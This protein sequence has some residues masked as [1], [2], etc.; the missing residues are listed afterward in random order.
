MQVSAINFSKLYQNN[1]KNSSFSSFSFPEIKDTVSFGSKN[2]VEQ[3]VGKVFDPNKT[4]INLDGIK[5]VV[6]RD[7]G[8]RVAYT[9]EEAQRINLF[10]GKNPNQI[11]SF[12]TEHNNINMGN[13][14]LKKYQAG[15]LGCV[16][17]ELPLAMKEA[18]IDVRTVLPYHGEL[19]DEADYGKMLIVRLP[20]DKRPKDGEEY[21]G[22]INPDWVHKV[23]SDYVPT[24]NEFFVVLNDTQ[25]ENKKKEKIGYQYVK[26]ED[27]GIKGEIEALKDGFFETEKI[28]YRIFRQKQTDKN[29]ETIYYVHIPQVAAMKKCY[30]K[31]GAYKVGFKIGEFWD[32]YVANCTRAFVNAMPDF[33]EKENFNPANV[34]LHDRQT[35]PVLF[36]IIRRS[37]EGQKFFNGIKCHSILHNPGFD[38]QG[39]FE[40]MHDFMKIMYDEKDFKTLQ[41]R[42]D[43][44]ELKELLRKPYEEMTKDEKQFI[45]EFFTPYFSELL[46][47][48]GRVNST[49]M[50]IAS[51]KINPE[52]STL[53]TVSR[54]YGE[55]MVKYTGIA[56][57]L[58]E[59]F[60]EVTDRIIN[61]T[62]GSL[63][64]SLGLNKRGNFAAGDNGLTTMQLEYSPYN[65]MLNSKNE[66]I[67]FSKSIY[68]LIKNPEK[69]EDKESLSKYSKDVMKNIYKLFNYG[70]KA[71]DKNTQQ[72]F[73]EY[74]KPIITAMTGN[75]NNNPFINTDKY[76]KEETEIN[77]KLS[78][79]EKSLKDKKISQDDYNNEKA[80][81]NK[82]KT[83]L[84]TLSFFNAVRSDIQNTDSSIL[85]KYREGLFDSVKKLMDKQASLMEKGEDLTKEEKAILSFL[86]TSLDNYDVYTISVKDACDANKKWFLQKI[87]DCYSDDKDET[88][89]KLNAL[90]LNSDQLKSGQSVYGSLKDVDPEN[91]RIFTN[92]GRPDFQ[93]GFPTFLQGYLEFLKSDA[94]E[95]DKKHAKL[96]F[97]TGGAFEKNEDGSINNE[98]ALLLKYLKEIQELDGGK[99]ANNVVMVEGI[100]PNKLIS[101]CDFGLFTSRFEPC[102]I[103]PFEC[104][105]AGRPVASIRTG[106]APN[107]VYEKN[108]KEGYKQTGFLTKTPFMVE[109]SDLDNFDSESLRADILDG[110]EDKPENWTKAMRKIYGDKLDEARREY[111]SKQ[112][113]DLFKCTMSV[114]KEEYNEISKTCCEQQIAWDKNA[115]YN[116][117]KKS[118]LRIYLEDIF[119]IYED[120]DNKGNKYFFFKE[121]NKEKLTKL[122][123]KFKENPNYSLLSQFA[124]TAV[125]FGARLTNKISST[126]NS[127]FN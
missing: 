46:D 55:E 114:S 26:V 123:G 75:N 16:T 2:P 104:F 111:M 34:L 108:N 62:N 6:L 100:F 51:A 74:A 1:V 45:V 68:E 58:T 84:T 117:G 23:N 36:D 92:W 59:Q 79:L 32:L 8:M 44:Y 14:A 125:S 127:Y 4:K 41:E 63:P 43:Y 13:G 97:G 50:V 24:N 90:F 48:Y 99:Y 113:S 82:R 65:P 22:E 72:A 121:H 17:K 115:Q 78:E 12:A 7:D 9:A 67:N 101:A 73:D 126:L 87:V 94:P 57:G 76:L 35:F 42:P 91:D 3:T 77:S 112:I 109:A 31:N 28:P 80:E 105:A 60:K 61:V 89:K 10:N 15:G 39:Y 107:F 118:A 96:V 95:K 21:K 71:D 70:I 54:N 83:A 103:T 69:N 11:I 110:E 66:M 53:G 5:Y 20:I 85:T 30:G 38:Y 116:G 93:K 29:T 47:D 119:G 106:G 52:N 18:G 33:A 64:A 27:T 86:A 56:E 120:K 81:L 19:V 98:K 102:G 122:T 49:K 40:K 88:K 124:D 25:K 37:A